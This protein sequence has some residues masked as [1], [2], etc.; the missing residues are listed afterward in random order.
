ML[1]F[2]P[3]LAETFKN[4]YTRIHEI[5]SF[6]T[7][8]DSTNCLTIRKQLEA[9]FNFDLT[10]Y[11]KIFAKKVRDAIVTLVAWR[12]PISNKPDHIWETTLK[13]FFTLSLG[14]PCLV[15]LST[16]L[17]KTRPILLGGGGHPAFSPISP[18]L[19]DNASFRTMV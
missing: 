14:H 7:D 8:L 19:T 15:L 2:S 17:N 4:M 5:L 10:P 11:K 1:H 13:I 16:G 9:E 18:S 12:D 6:C 3:A